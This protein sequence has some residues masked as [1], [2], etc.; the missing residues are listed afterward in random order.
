MFA[1]GMAW[2]TTANSL[3]V[4]AQRG[5]P[6][7]VRARGMSMYQMALMGSSAAGAALWGQVA[8]WTS[9]HTSVLVAALT[10]LPTLLLASR[11]LGNTRVEEDQTPTHTLQ[12]PKV[13]SPP[14][15]GQV[16]VAI[17]YL[18]DP[19]RVED[20]R[21]LMQLSRSSRLRHGVLSWELLRDIHQRGRFVEQYVDPSWNEHL[22][23]FDRLT[24]AGAALRDRRF[25]FHVGPRP[26]R[27]TRCVVESTVR[28]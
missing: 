9:V 2:I 19:A 6:D 3:S 4:S 24:A 27:V 20:F 26:P 12:Q 10:G 28:D 1:S 15:S 13:D 25:G 17:E 18:I 16:L 23:R 5:L 21:A 7:W 14:V 8:T 11:L 22:R